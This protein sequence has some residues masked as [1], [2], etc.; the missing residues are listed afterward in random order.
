MPNRPNITSIRAYAIIIE[1]GQML[2]CRLSEDSLDPGLWTLP[3]GGGEFGE[4]PEETCHREVLEETGLQ[5]K[6]EPRPWVISKL[7][8]NPDSRINS[9]R[10]FYLAKVVGGDLRAEIN[11]STD[12]AEWVPLSE[13]PNLWLADT[14]QFAL[15]V[16]EV[17][18]AEL[19]P[20]SR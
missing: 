18:A 1:S 6:L 11:G 17:A 3:G 9:V 4:S 20:T 15:S 8:E 13:L 16:T 7:W 2:L 19:N 5:V 10:F 12:V 14:V